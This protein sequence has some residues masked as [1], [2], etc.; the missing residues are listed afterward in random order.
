MQTRPLVR[1]RGVNKSFGALQANV[2]VSFDLRP[3]AI[4]ALL[5]ENGA[6]KST[7]MNVLAGLYVP[8]SGHIEVD[9]ERLALGSPRAS[10]AAGVGMVHQQFRLVESLSGFENIS[11]ALHGGRILQP[12][13]A[14]AKLKA[15]MEEL[16][17]NIDL[18]TPVH[19]MSLARRQQ[20]EILRTI[21]A[22]ARVLVLDEPTSVLSAV[23]THGLFAI[24]RRIVASGRSVILISHK[25][26]EVLEV[27]DE[28]VV[29]RSGRVVHKG[30]TAGADPDALSRHIV[31]DRSFV[32]DARPERAAGEIVLRV[33]K[34]DVADHR[35]ATVVHG[36]D[37]AV[38]G[39]EVVAILGVTGNGQTELMEAIGGLRRPVSG[40]V[41]APRHNKRRAFAYIPA[42]HLGT[43][44]APGLVLRENAILGH[45]RRLGGRGW[46][47]RHV[48][49]A[50]AGHVKGRFGVRIDEHEPV[51]RLSGGNLQR[52]VLG[53]E[54]LDDP[55]LIV[56][57]YPTR[58]LDVASAAQIRSALVAAAS[59]GAGVLLS[60][61]EIS[62]SL[63]IATRVL[64]M[65][66]GEVVADLPA[67]EADR[68]RIGRLMTRGRE[69]Q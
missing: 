47:Q 32:T 28:V 11:L 15:L 69:A 36:A 2:D 23:E 24:M 6:G 66:G 18:A 3:G 31:G 22:G 17:F 63:A 1:F 41:E 27:A 48:L 8:D 4:L 57:D 43:A 44:L 35:G 13:S 26:T 30:P 12:R 5:G 53:R 25:L 39:G 49:N 10:V 68:E 55:S 33:D 60:S 61:E 20:L 45:Q 7:I 21:A 9:G 52:V 40:Q 46:L 51:R 50:R 59:K 58:G 16:G 19:A 37:F 65:H 14:D 38:R 34:L 56:A 67:A 64:V 29:M 42:Q 54:L 62:E